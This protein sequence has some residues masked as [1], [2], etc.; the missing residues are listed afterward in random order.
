MPKLEKKMPAAKR[1]I[2][3]SAW[4]AAET[5]QSDIED[6]IEPLIDKLD[7]GM[8]LIAKQLGRGTKEYLKLRSAKAALDKALADFSHQLYNVESDLES[9]ADPV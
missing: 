8:D 3:F 7:K 2:L 6:D 5:M 9:E 1:K 4:S